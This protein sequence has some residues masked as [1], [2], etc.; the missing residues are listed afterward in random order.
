MPRQKITQRNDGRYKVKY[1]DKQ[2]YGKTQAEALRK[3]DA[4]IAAEK[5]GFNH[6]FETVSFHD[7]AMRWLDVYKPGLNRSQRQQYVGL[8]DFASEMIGKATLKDITPTDLQALCNLLSPYSPSY[9]NKF[10]QLLRGIFRAAVAD[11]ALLRNPMDTVK[12]PKTKK[13]EGHRAL[14]QWERQLVASTC[15]EHDFGLCAMVM[16]FAGLRRG[17]ALYLDIDRDVDFKA[18]TITVRGAVSFCNGNQALVTDGKT[19]AAKRTIPLVG[20]LE[21]ALRGHHGLLCAKMDGTIMSESA[22]QRKLESYLC[23]LEKKVNGCTKR[24][25]GKTREHKALLA[26]GEELPPWRDVK[27]RC[28]DFRVDFCTRAYEA[29][30]PLKTLQAWMGHS[31]AQME[32]LLSRGNYTFF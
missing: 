18:K 26:A 8:I 25:Y 21:D 23:F 5:A 15:Q 30:I 14:E 7:Y 24:W 17:E 6:D 11:G 3:R 2:F 28:H 13:C 20:P 32:A 12:R 4:W 10:M 22:F 31:D 19:E 27:I 1:H 29:G 16:L 9:A